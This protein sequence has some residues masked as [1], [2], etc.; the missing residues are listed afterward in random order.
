MLRPEGHRGMWFETEPT[1]PWD[2][3]VWRSQKFVGDPLELPTLGPGTAEEPFHGKP[4]ICSAPLS[5]R[6]DSIGIE[7]TK[8]F[9]GAQLVSDHHYYMCVYSIKEQVSKVAWPGGFSLTHQ[10]FD[11]STLRDDVRIDDIRARKAPTL[12]GNGVSL[13]D[14]KL[15][16]KCAYAENFDELNA[17]SMVDYMKFEAALGS[18]EPCSP[19]VSMYQLIYNTRGK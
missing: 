18:D 14:P 3:A 17:T 10:S 12:P 15:D 1:D 8:A 16:L 9:N 13:S 6:L 5:E 4:D 11:K 2:Q 7:R 19:V